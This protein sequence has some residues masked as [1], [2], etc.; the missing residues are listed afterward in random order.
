[1]KQNNGNMK[2]YNMESPNGNKVANQF[3]IY[4][5]EG[6]YFQSYKSIIAFIDNNGKVFLDDYYWDYSR[7]TGKYRNMFL[8]N[9]IDE[10]REKIK[11]GEYEL[12][13]L[14]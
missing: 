10:A 13:N 8:N 2:V 7:T 4:T 12:K 1:M 5:D 14:N 3:E 6:K 9:N 11:S